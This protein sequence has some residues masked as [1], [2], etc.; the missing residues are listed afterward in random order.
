MICNSYHGFLSRPHSNFYFNCCFAWSNL[1][2][3]NLFMNKKVTGMAYI[4]VPGTWIIDMR[5]CSFFIHV[6]WLLYVEELF[7]FIL[8]SWWL[9]YVAQETLDRREQYTIISYSV[10]YRIPLNWSWSEIQLGKQCYMQ[11][12]WMP[13]TFA[14]KMKFYTQV[15]IPTA[16]VWYSMIRP[17]AKIRVL[18]SKIS[19]L[20]SRHDTLLQN[21]EKM[22]SVKLWNRTNPY[23]CSWMYPWIP[24]FISVWNHILDLKI[25]VNIRP[26][27]DWRGCVNLC[28][29]RRIL[30]VCRFYFVFLSL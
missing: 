10:V 14:L 22:A 25:L 18:P 19:F 23:V 30:N 20:L 11:C 27:V 28:I 12:K 9:K 3:G 17:Q 1:C 24:Y 15:L 21:I 2:L 5:S 7:C 26:L 16:K 13:Y 8:A 4:F 6:V 29:H